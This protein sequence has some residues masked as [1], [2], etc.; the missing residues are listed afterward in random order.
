MAKTSFSTGNQTLRQLLG[1]GMRYAVPIFQRDYSWTQDEWDDLW[2]DIQ[3]TLAPASD[4]AHYMGYL[5]LQTRDNKQFAVVDGQQRLTT[6]SLL[7]LA[8]LKVLQDLVDTGREPS[9]N[10]LRINQLR[11]TYVGYLDLVTL[12]SRPKLELNRRNNAYFQNYIVPLLPLPKTRFRSDELLRKG[13]EFFYKKLSELA[14]IRNDG[15]ALAGFLEALSDRMFFS[16]ITLDDE[17][18]AFTVFETLNARGVKLSPTDLLKNYLFS[19]VHKSDPHQSEMETLEQRWEEI[20]GKLGE[21]SFPDFLR[22]HWNSRNPLVRESGLFKAVR[23]TT[24]DKAAV[25]ALLRRLDE[26]VDT[27]VALGTPE[28]PLWNA[29]QR[30]HV[31]DLKLFGIRQPWSLLLAARRMFG[32]DEFTRIVE[33]LVVV[34]FRYNLISSGAT[35]DQETVYNATARDINDKKIARVSGVLK[36]LKP[37]YP[38]DLEFSAAFAAKSFRTAAGRNKAL[39]MY[40][41]F[42]LEAAQG[43]SLDPF[44]AKY[45]LEHIF[46]QNPGT[47][48]PQFTFDDGQEMLNR[49]GN[50]AVLETDLNK[51]MGNADFPAKRAVFARS[52]ILT[53]RSIAQENL[54]WDAGRIAARQKHQAEIACTVWRIAQLG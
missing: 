41:L 17:L 45:S 35:G 24:K 11:G 4:S 5:V 34:S 20:T 50:C 21:E 40:I 42:R 3:S 36:G 49:L 22:V 16:V 15:A 19:V 51:E 10:Q 7:A 48:W 27:F 13:F 38:A 37:V 31:R 43:P 23:E 1:N 12:V 25:F 47:H 44:N 14:A 46:P 2:Q 18:D 6:F 32:D 39:V 33:A 53:T 30:R 52:D 9:D 29:D 8:V 54:D 26:D 28:S